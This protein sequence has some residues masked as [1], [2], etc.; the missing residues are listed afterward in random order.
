MLL[1]EIRPDAD[2]AFLANALLAAVSAR[3]IERYREST[4]AG[5]AEVKAGVDQLL[6]G[7]VGRPP[8]A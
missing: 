6:A 2:A 8:E 1:R 7:V 4:G 5:L 3:A